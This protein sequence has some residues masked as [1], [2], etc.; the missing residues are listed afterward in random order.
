MQK[1]WHL[2]EEIP[3]TQSKQL[4]SNLNTDTVLAS[5]LLQRGIQTYDEAKS[6]FRPKLEDCH[7]PFDLLNMRKAV[8]RIQKALSQNERVLLYGDYDVDGTTSVALMH[9]FLSSRIANL[10]YYV[11]DRYAEGYGVSI[12][13]MEFA[14]QEKIDLIIT[15]DCGIKNKKELDWAVEQGMEVIICDHHEPGEEVPN[16]IILNPKQKKCSYPCKDLS[17]AGVAF[18]LLQACVAEGIGSEEELYGL[19]DFVAIS[20]GADIVNVLGENRILA[21]HGMK[22]LN[23]NTRPCFDILLRVAGR[24]KPVNLTDVV[25]SIAPRIN[26]AGRIHLAT[27]AV[28]LMLTNDKEEIDKMARLIDEY[29][30]TRRELDENVTIEA[31]AQIKGFEDYEQRRTNVVF[32]EGWSKGIV[33]IVASRIIEQHFKP[34]IVFSE[35]EG[36]LTG[37][38][39]TVN[40]FDIHSSLVEC[41]DLLLKFGGHTHAAGL[42]LT[43]EKLPEFIDRFEQV[44]AERIALEDL[45]PTE[46]ISMEIS[47][48]DLFKPGESRQTIPRLKR[49]LD[50]MEPFGPGNMKPVFVARNLYSTQAK[51]LKE[52]HLKLRVI[53][54]ANNIE[55]DGIGFSMA[56]KL[57]DVAPG[58][59]FDI[60]FTMETNTWQNRS[61]V[62]LNIKDIR[63]H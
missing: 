38:A 62:Q 27:D 13:G 8:E 37:S 31:L 15:L 5:L 7:S 9:H 49:L 29:N 11:P 35:A 22:L 57:D 4:A 43:R 56:D 17:G 52:K 60:A 26:A 32:K 16:A 30:S 41:E 54:P 18:K 51:V 42:S 40:N 34:T 10:Q 59:A 48:D 45:A 21:Y 1:R 47:F 2:S 46:Y 19:L 36:I 53:Q 28:K 12:I 24:S 58:V 23:E 39:R 33:G 55:L 25:F 3:A 61:T 6:F 20:I 44:V 50:Q 14:L 63:P